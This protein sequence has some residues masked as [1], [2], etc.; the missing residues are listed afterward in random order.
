M[1]DDITADRAILRVP[2][3]QRASA[4]LTFV[5]GRSPSSSHA[6]LDEVDKALIDHL[7]ADGKIT[8]RELAQRIGVSESVVSM[9]LRKM[10]ASGLLVFAAIIDW[11]VA[12]FDWFV[13]CR[14]KTRGR[15]PRD[16]AQDIG[17]FPQCDAVAV[18]VGSYDVLA[19]FLVPDLAELRDVI[20]ELATIHGVSD[21][22]VDLAIETTV[23][24]YGRQ[25]FLSRNA[26]PIRLP[27][28]KIDLDEI[29]IAIMQQL[30]DDGRQSSRNIA[31]RLHVS[32][33]T[34]RAR[35]NRLIQ[36]GLVRVVAMVE[37]VAL[38]VIGVIASISIRADRARLH[39]IHK[40]LAAV[41]NVVFSAICLG[42]WDMHV[43]VTATTAYQL[44]Q[45]VG[46]IQAIDGVTATDA[47]L[48]T[49]VIRLSSYMKRLDA[50]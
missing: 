22:D 6:A 19:Y 4:G 29:D 41:P 24:Q 9:R 32:E 20:N 18:S 12:G 48:M 1:N 25:L 2:D 38:G 23:P 37:P 35:I 26:P 15:S 31:R 49:D 8:N 43:T 10:T 14:I 27:A 28:P 44:M 40:E 16:V 50:A 47:M 42:S 45:I 13:I 34:V 46:T 5:D 36:S 30:I 3:V 17:V 33:G 7:L 11:E 39:Y 21:L